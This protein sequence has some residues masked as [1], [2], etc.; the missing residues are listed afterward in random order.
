MIP[1][2][3]QP[4]PPEFHQRVRVPGQDFL[5]TNPS[6]KQDD[7]DGKEHWRR[8]IPDLRI[9]YRGICAYSSLRILPIEVAT[10]DH[11]VPRKTH[12]HLAYEWSNFRLARH[13]INS[14][15]GEFTVLDPFTI[16]DDW[17]V[18]DF[19]TFMVHPNNNLT[20]VQM[21]QIRETIQRLD[22]NHQDYVEMRAEW[23]TEFKNNLQALERYSPF[24]AY[25]MRRQEIVP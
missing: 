3:P 25:E 17:F 14:K 4:E 7:W 22:L 12:P 24:I 1:V 11:F 18:L 20:E 5:M 6:P 10:V 13:R 21:G 8:A 19:S 2:Q 16:G 9:A 23:Y 15:K